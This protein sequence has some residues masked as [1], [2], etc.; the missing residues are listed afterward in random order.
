MKLPPGLLAGLH[1]G[2][3]GAGVLQHDILV[4]QCLVAGT[5]FR[6]LKQ[7]GDNLLK[8]VRLALKREAKNQHDKFAVSLLY[9]DCNIGYLPRD[10]NETI[11]RLLDAGKDF[12]AIITARDYEG[13]WLRL[14]IDVFL[15]DYALRKAPLQNIS[16]YLCAPDLQKSQLPIT[17]YP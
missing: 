15:R 3:I 6:D 14:D 12:Y 17:K 8:G 13:S 2:Q 9:N 10:K 16:P 4:L 7:H 1:S 5:T 11:A